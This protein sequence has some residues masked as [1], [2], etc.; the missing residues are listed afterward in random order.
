VLVDPRN[1]A[2]HVRADDRLSRGHRFEL[3]VAEG[4]GPRHGGKDEQR[5]RVHQLPKLRVAHLASERDAAVERERPRQALPL[6]ALRA[7]SRDDRARRTRRQRAQEDIH[8]F[9]AHVAS[10]KERERLAARRRRVGAGGPLR[11]ID[12]ERNDPHAILAGRERRRVLPERGRRHDDPAG[13]AVGESCERR[14]EQRVLERG[15]HDVA[16]IPDHQRR[17]RARD[18]VGQQRPGIGLVQDDEVR[19]NPSQPDGE[20]GRDVYRA[21]GRDRA[22]PRHVHAVARL[23]D[24]CAGMIRHEHVILDEPAARLTERLDDTLHASRMRRVELADV[25]HAHHET[26]G[27]SAGRP[28]MLR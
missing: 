20:R 18:R 21:R 11:R 9:V 19:R 5:A 3:D 28:A 14:V 10:G 26:A 24:S 22:D 16:V 6:G 15:P 13:A 27:S 7:V 23:L 12:A 17:L 8:A 1:T 2:R 25:K 4:L